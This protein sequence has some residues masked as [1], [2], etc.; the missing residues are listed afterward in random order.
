VVVALIAGTKFTGRYFVQVMAQSAIDKIPPGPKLD[1]LT[2]EKV[3]GW[4][5]VHKHEGALVGKKQDK[6]GR[7]RLAKVPY[8]STNPLHALSVEDRMKQLGRLDRFQKELAKITRAKNIPSEWASPDQR[9]RAA[10]KAMGQYGRVI[11]LR[12]SGEE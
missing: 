12:K 7:W 1:A 2:A 3:F 9:C 10:I 5:N 8:Y 6:A 11:P 4:K